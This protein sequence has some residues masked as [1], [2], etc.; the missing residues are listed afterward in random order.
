MRNYTW[1]LLL[2]C[3]SLF[4]Q[5]VHITGSLRDAQNL[6]VSYAQII[7]ENIKDDKIFKEVFTEDN[8]DFQADVPAG[9]YEISIQ[10]LN[11]GLIKRQKILNSD[12]NF[13]T[14]QIETG[15][16][17][18][19]EVKAMGSKPLY[20]LELDKRVYDMERDPS[21]RG[22]SISDALNN[23]PSIQVDTD[24]TISL[25]G[26]TDLRVLIDGKPS[27]MTGIS[28]VSEALKNLPAESVQRVE[29]ITNPSA[30]YDA[31]GTAGIIN[32]IMK[33]GSN[34]GFNANFSTTLGLPEQESFSANMN[35]KTKKW[36]FFI[37]PNVSH[38]NSTGKRSF[39]NVF[40][41]EKRK[42]KSMEMQ[43]GDMQGK[44]LS[45]GVNLGVDH[46][47]TEKTSL[48]LSGNYRYDESK[49]TNTS[50]YED[51]AYGVIS[52]KSQRL[53]N[54][55]EFDTSAEAN[56]S[57][58]HEF[59][60]NGHELNFAA[61]TSY[62]K[63]DENSNIL[64][65]SI[66]G[67]KT[68]TNQITSNKE[69]Q[70]RN[71][72]KLDYVLPLGEK[73]RFEFGY[74]GEWESNNSDYWVQSLENSQWIIKP[75]FADVL[76]YDQNI[77][78]LYSQWG[79]KFGRFSYLLGLRMEASDIKIQSKNASGKNKK[80][81]SWFPTATFNYS[82]DNE[83]KNQIQISYS[84]RIRRPMGQFLSPF[85]NYS[86]DR[87][88][89]LGNPNLD[90]TF[91]DAYELA[92]ITQLGNVSITPSIYYRHS[93]DEINVFRRSAEIDGSQIFI[94]QPINV[95]SQNSYGVEFT[96]SAPVTKWW[97]LFSNFNFYKYQMDA[98][99]NDPLSQKAYD[100]SSD[101]F[102]WFG[103][104]SNSLK[105]PAKIEGQLSAFYHGPMQNAQ[106]KNKA[107]FGIDLALSKDILNGNG[108]L[109]LN[110]R[111]LLN[112]RKR[113]TES[114]GE[115]YLSEME[116]QWRPRSIL[117][118]SYRINQKKKKERQARED[119][120]SDEMVEF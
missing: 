105:L 27:A 99:Y 42:E 18:L 53:E 40:L 80:Y 49:N 13:G 8:G 106:S 3:A 87:N 57:L 41:D 94:T 32:I 33:K 20:R 86:D 44:R 59:N 104:I 70:T 93:Q 120:G 14:I 88:I 28:N 15:S 4:A 39:T 107:M 19:S 5:N 79:N 34:I 108:T 43:K 25:R 67:N 31:E 54:E 6:P 68:E 48:S 75:G 113:R 81:T 55:K 2:L 96:L 101:A 30:R 98:I 115:D 9:T 45:T 118:F 7:F 60:K 17:A 1:I 62:G 24:G 21:V 84:R 78:A 74:K 72:L 95:G 110:A 89:F 50:N 116:M 66:L 114:Y 46:Y 56:F 61:S 83:E 64:G 51:F 71:F 58:K 16:I 37:N 91:T 12:T 69:S 103:R 109:T 119:M 97:H 38:S 77:Q 65:K 90:P 76:D 35:I 47:L 82:L 22:A 52:G 63:E 23:V 26:N 111:D 85:N 92:Y 73:S 36:N 100:L 117:S 10:P 112:S 29:V 11:G 102:N